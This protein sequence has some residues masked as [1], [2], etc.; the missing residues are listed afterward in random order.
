MKKN[1]ALTEEGKMKSNSLP[2]HH[3]VIPASEAR[4]G[5]DSLIVQ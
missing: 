1:Q 2:D 3:N 4:R 5:S